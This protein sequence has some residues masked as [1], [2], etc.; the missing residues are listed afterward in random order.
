MYNRNVKYVGGKSVLLADTFSR[1]VMPGKDKEIQGLDVTIAQ[2]LKIRPIQLEQLQ[3]E[4]MNGTDLQELKDMITSGWPESIS[5]VSE[6]TKPNW[7]FRDEMAVLDGL[8]L[9]GNRVVVP[10]AMR[11]E[12]LARLHDGHQG[13]S[14]TL[15]RARRTVY[16]PKMQDDISAMQLKCTECQ[17]HAK[18]KP[19]FPE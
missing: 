4:T 9:K 7:C 15:Q 10:T 12:T 5:D 13:I 16:W 18:K 11:H 14:P 17:M 2:V 19:R 8:V 6:A 3:E 1:L